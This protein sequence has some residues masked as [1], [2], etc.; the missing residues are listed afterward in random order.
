MPLLVAMQKAGTPVALAT[1]ANQFNID[2]ILEGLGL[3]DAFTAVIGAEAIKN[4]KPHPE[5]FLK[6]AEA[7]GVAPEECLVFEDSFMGIEAA[8]RANMDVYA[9]LTTLSEAE[10]QAL[11]NVIGAAPD[12][13]KIKQNFLSDSPQL[14]NYQTNRLPD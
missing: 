4:G 10:A 14:L 12:F 2:F 11:P 9:I 13:S 6:A 3:Q 5:I 8:H 1:S 7:L